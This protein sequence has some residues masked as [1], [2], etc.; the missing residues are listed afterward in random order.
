M[1]ALTRLSRWVT[2]LEEACL[3]GGI[4]GIALLT[5]ANVLGRVLFDHSLAF[6]EEISQFLIV[7]VT[8]LGI[9]YG[10]GKGRHIRMTALYDQ[11]PKPARKRLA[12]LISASTSLLL[13][14]LTYLGLSYALGTVRALGSVSPVLEVPLWLVYLSAPLGFAL[15]GIQYGLAVAKNLVADEVWLSYETRD[16]VSGPP[17]EGL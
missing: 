14:Y 3:A 10:V 16:D 6:A 11:L 1:G 17:P 9:G 12:I 7:F 2:R 13:F 4:L 8:F 5:I 15:G